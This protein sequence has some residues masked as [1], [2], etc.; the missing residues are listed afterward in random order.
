MGYQAHCVVMEELSRASG[1]NSTVKEAK[2]AI[3]LRP[4]VAQEVSVSP[5][6]LTPSSVS[7]NSL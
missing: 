4:I 5:T 7:T 2:E 1:K 3:Y 6:L